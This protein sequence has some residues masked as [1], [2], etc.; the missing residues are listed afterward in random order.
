RDAVGCIALQLAIQRGTRNPQHAGRLELVSR[1]LL[2][3]PNDVA[4]LDLV[5]REKAVSLAHGRSF[6]NHL[7]KI[8]RADDLAWREDHRVLDDMV[9][10]ADVSRPRIAAQNLER[11]GRERAH[12]LA[13]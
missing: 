13:Q 9:E 1:G 2:Q 3:D 5:E 6:P 11:P 10:L 12:G 8:A 7:G 4:P